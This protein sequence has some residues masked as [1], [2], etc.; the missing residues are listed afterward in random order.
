M[1]DISTSIVP[2]LT[3]YPNRFEKAKQIVEWLTDIK[4]IKGDKADCILSSALGYPIDSGAVVLTTEPKQL[5]FN[6][7]VNGLQVVTEPSVFDA[8]ENGL[9]SVICPNCKEDILAEEWNLEGFIKSENPLLE[10]PLCEQQSDLNS[11]VIEP[12]WG[13]SNLGFTFWNW[14]GFTDDFIKEFEQKLGCKVKVVE[15]II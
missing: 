14:T 2:E 8:G 6:L 15:S 13:F 11:Y 3:I 12:T 9:D 4:A 5:P 7:V 1:S 10:C